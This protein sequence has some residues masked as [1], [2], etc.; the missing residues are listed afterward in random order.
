VKY[1]HN[2]TTTL[3]RISANTVGSSFK[4]YYEEHE[5]MKDEPLTDYNPNMG[6]EEVLSSSI[7]V[8]TM[9]LY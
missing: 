4:L 2:G 7:Q 5:T 9:D 1:F 6:R 3:L 8:W